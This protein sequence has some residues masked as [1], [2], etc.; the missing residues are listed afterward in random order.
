MFSSLL[1]QCVVLFSYVVWWTL[2]YLLLC[3]STFHF[4]SNPL[5]KMTDS[6]LLLFQC[7]WSRKGF[8]RTRWCI[9][10]WYVASLNYFWWCVLSVFLLATIMEKVFIYIK[11]WLAPKQLLE[12]IE[13]IT[14]SRND[15]QQDVIW[16][17]IHMCN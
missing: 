2:F 7:K 1:S 15:A 4:H 5:L 6:Y 13:H 10:D 14:I 9:T 11:N 16:I 8:I 3:V 12:F 17:F